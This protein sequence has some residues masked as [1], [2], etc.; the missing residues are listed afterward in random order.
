MATNIGR[1]Q[2]AGAQTVLRALLQR[3]DALTTRVATLEAART[4]GGSLNAGGQRVTGVAS[5]QSDSDA[6]NLATLR[7]YVNAVKDTSL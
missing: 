3:V 1:V 2:D 5:P 4:S 6:V 7:S